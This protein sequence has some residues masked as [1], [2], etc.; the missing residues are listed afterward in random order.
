VATIVIELPDNLKALHEPVAALLKAVQTTIAAA[1]CARSVDY[2]AV[3]ARFAERACAIERA[4]HQVTLQALDIDAPALLVAGKRFTR[5]LRTTGTFKTMAGEVSVEHSRYRADHERNGRTVDAITLRTGAVGDGWLPA[6]AAAMAH[7]VQQSTSRE[8]AAQAATTFRLPYSRSA[9]EDV[10]HLVGE[11]LL[12][13]RSEV[14]DDLMLRFDVPAEARSISVSLDRVTIPMEEPR[15][16]PVGRPKAGAPKKPI[17]RVFRMG[18]VGTVSLHDDKGEALHT[19]RYGRMPEG[20]VHGLMA[21]L[22]ADTKALLEKRP[23]LR[24]AYLADGAPE[25]WD[26]LEGWIDEEELG[27]EPVKLLDFWHVAEKLA[28]ALRVIGNEALLAR[29]KFLLLNRVDAVDT[30]LDELYASGKRKVRVGQSRPV[31]D[32]IT[33]L[34][35]NRDLMNYTTAR[36]RQLPIGSGIAEATCKSL[37]EVRMKRSGSRWKTKS[38]DHILHLRALALSDRWDDGVQLTLKHLRKPVKRAA[39]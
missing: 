39:A 6:T 35:N 13:C 30:I 29:W 11:Q 12:Q 28:A 25:L 36:R 32:A 19:I 33:Y 24:L 26:W 16:K 34:E 2:A 20:D 38:G 7:A 10:A 18:Y 1:S 3:E 5:V 21:A 27:V 22:E 8:A 23:D 15:P 17:S 31:H 4:C 9:F 37:F 14:E